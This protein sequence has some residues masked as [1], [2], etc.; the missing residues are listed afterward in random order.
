MRVGK[1]G[2]G[3]TSTQTGHT[4]VGREED[5]WREENGLEIM[6]AGSRV[7][8]CGLG[9]GTYGLGVGTDLVRILGGLGCGGSLNRAG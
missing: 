8:T 3:G 7:G 2:S 1:L 6:N 9:V 5:G 4:S